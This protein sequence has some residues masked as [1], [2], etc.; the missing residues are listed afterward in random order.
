MVRPVKVDDNATAVQTMKE[1]M[2]GGITIRVYEPML[3]GLV[4]ISGVCYRGPMYNMGK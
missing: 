1:F 3:C 2:K 4:C